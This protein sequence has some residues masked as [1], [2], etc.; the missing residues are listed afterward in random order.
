MK[1]YFIIIIF[2]FIIPLFSCQAAIKKET[3]LV[4][5][6]YISSFSLVVQEETLEQTIKGA[7]MTA[8]EEATRIWTK[9]WARIKDF[10]NT[11]IV[12][13]AQNIWHRIKDFFQRQIDIRRPIIE[14]ELEEEKEEVIEKIEKYLEEEKQGF[15]ERI[16]EFF[17]NIWQRTLETIQRPFER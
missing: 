3:A 8:L 12:D 5:L 9:M 2:I 15:R 17:R 7:F 1:N 11:Y 16:S 6:S 4:D 13:M 14:R 10:W